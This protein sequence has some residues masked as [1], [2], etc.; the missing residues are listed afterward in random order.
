[1]PEVFEI[2]P[3]LCGQIQSDTRFYLRSFNLTAQQWAARTKSVYGPLSQL[4]YAEITF[5]LR[6]RR[7]SLA[8][9]AFLAR[10][11]GQSGLIR[12]WDPKRPRPSLNIEAGPDQA[13]W[14][15]GTGWTDGTLWDETP[16][17]PYAAVGASETRGATSFLAEGLPASMARSLSAG[18][19]VE[20]RPDGAT[21]EHGHLYE[22]TNDAPTDVYGRT[23]LFIS[24]GLRTGI[25]AGDQIVMKR[26]MTVFRLA[27]DDQEGLAHRG[28][29]LS[30]ATIKLIEALP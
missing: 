6:T 23:R 7:D 14:T 5:T 19:I 24:P 15:D 18:D 26:A 13:S 20:I 4:W 16:V 27:D 8:L 28:A 30:S 2:P 1:M 9:D 10:A 29:G 25:R 11:G 12:M 21:A 22:V 3:Q 17:P